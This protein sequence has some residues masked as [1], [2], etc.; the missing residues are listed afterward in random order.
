M[1]ILKEY[2]MK[3]K[4]L[5]DLF[6]PQEPELKG[7]ISDNEVFAI[8]R[9]DFIY[10]ETSLTRELLGMYSSKG[11]TFEMHSLL[12]LL[13]AYL[14]NIEE[15]RNINIYQVSPS[16]TLLSIFAYILT[17]KKSAAVCTYAPNKINDLQC[18]D[19]LAIEIFKEFKVS[20][21]RSLIPKPTKNEVSIVLANASKESDVVAG[22]SIFAQATSGMFII[23]GYGR[24]NSPNCSEAFLRENVHVHTNIV[25]FSVGFK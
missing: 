25:G 22:V 4:R 14:F 18:R 7:V 13:Q 3:S 5:A 2:Q 12:D 16:L 8:N 1:N 17:L 9:R 6:P 11:A 19:D 23:K 24:L 20:L 10:S 15:K 21:K